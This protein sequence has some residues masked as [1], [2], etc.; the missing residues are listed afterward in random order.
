MKQHT[1]MFLLALILTFSIQT[2]AAM[3]EEVVQIQKQWAQV[4]YMPDGDAKEKAFEKLSKAATQIRLK[5]PK[6]AESWIWE[7]IIYSSYAGA[8]GGISALGLAKKAKAAYEE[9]LNIDEDALNGSAHTSIGVL[10]HKVPGWPLSFGSD[11]KAVKHLK[12]GLVM[13]PDGIDSNFFYAQY[14]VEE[15]SDYLNAKNYLE[16]A[17]EASPRPSRPVADL[18]RRKEV[19]LLLA[20]VV[21]ELED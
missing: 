7:G 11:K 20:E 13:N 2:K 5:H 3:S 21:K 15:E 8:K 18:E 1:C 12:K 4:N 6:D 14:L 17:L 10:F 9:A 16:K 19:K